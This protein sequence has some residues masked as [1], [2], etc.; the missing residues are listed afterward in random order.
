[1]C[2]RALPGRRS[3]ITLAQGWFEDRREDSGPWRWSEGDLQFRE[4]S[5]PRL[6][7]SWIVTRALV[8]TDG[9][10][11]EHG[12]RAKALLCGDQKDESRTE[13]V[14]NVDG[15][16]D[17]IRPIRVPSVFHPGQKN[18]AVGRPAPSSES[19]AAGRKTRVSPQDS[20][21][22]VRCAEGDDERKN[23]GPGRGGVGRHRRRTVFP[24]R[25]LQWDGMESPSY[26]ASSEKGGVRRP[27]PSIE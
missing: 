24:G 20:K 25:H 18:G 23:C 3:K 11:I 22:L 4:E 7:A 1:L 2:V 16:P 13:S 8:A 12:F 10:Q 5:P 6:A 27:A 14:R 26:M 19:S 15:L 17:A 9:T 21:I